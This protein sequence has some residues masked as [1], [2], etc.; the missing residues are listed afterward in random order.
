M[1]A[2]EIVRHGGIPRIQNDLE[3]ENIENLTEQTDSFHPSPNHLKAL[4]IL[5][6]MFCL[7]I[8]YIY[9]YPDVCSITSCRNH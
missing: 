4:E 2:N 6:H 8:N 7:H 3:I 9:S 5:S 1:Q